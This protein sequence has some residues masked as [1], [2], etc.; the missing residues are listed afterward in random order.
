MYG[1]EE[2]KAMMSSTILVVVNMD[3]HCQLSLKALRASNRKLVTKTSQKLLFFKH[4]DSRLFFD[5]NLKIYFFNKS[6]NQ[7]F[8]YS[9]NPQVNYCFQKIPL[10]LGKTCVAL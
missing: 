10:G 1:T 3:I 8:I 9:K 2:K 5:F 7:R 4:R 6:L